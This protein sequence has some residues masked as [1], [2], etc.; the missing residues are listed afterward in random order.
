MASWHRRPDGLV[1][2]LVLL[3]A[4]FNF[5]GALFT[6]Q[7]VTEEEVWMKV[8]KDL[9]VLALFLVLLMHV[10]RNDAWRDL[11]ARVRPALAPRRVARTLLRGGSAQQ[12]AAA[13]LAVILMMGAFMAFS[14]LTV[15]RPSFGALASARYYLFYPLLALAV[16]LAGP[17]R[18]RPLAVGIVVLGGVQTVLAVMDYFGVFGA[19]YYFGLTEF[20]GYLYPRAIG[21]L[22]NP[23]NLGIYLSLALILVIS[24][25]EHR[26]R[27][28][29]LAIAVLLVGILLTVSRTAPIALLIAFAGSLWGGRGSRR[30]M[31]TLLAL[32]GVAIAFA[33]TAGSRLGV[34]SSGIFG[35]RGATA[36][37]AL[38][39]WTEG[40]RAFLI[41]HGFASQATVG[42]NNAV[43][44]T[45]I[46]NMALAIAVEGGLVALVL[47][48]AIIVLGIRMAL[49]APATTRLGT[50]ARRYGLFF[51][52]YTPLAVNFRLFPG[53][54]FFWVLAGL[55]AG[56]GLSSR[57]RP[58]TRAAAPRDVKAG[59]PLESS[60][61]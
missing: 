9:P 26:S 2:W 56:V 43:Q 51:L 14:F 6:N 1:A 41:G 38:A 24:T 45:V 60:I 35:S 49:F 15:E 10:R 3:V 20:A 58:E 31:N 48:T 30:L 4:V 52:V 11:V 25:G 57:P 50:V 28:G 17:L 16:A 36:E 23:N 53:V 40:P 27:W 19:T 34:G 29:K 5:T 7:S 47:L 44:E 37:N 55:S 18:M 12:V 8:L 61:S 22:G 46:D 54:L 39:L 13:L 32:G 59:R 21:T 42:A 33:L